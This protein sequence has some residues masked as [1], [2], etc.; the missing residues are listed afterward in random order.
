MSQTQVD[1]KIITKVDSRGTKIRRI[2]CPPGYKLND[3]G[4]SCVPITGS[5]KMQKRIAMRKA[6]RTKRSK[7]PAAQKRANRKRLRAL[8]K[9]KQYGLK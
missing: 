9:R 2:K 3:N 5:E 6:I 1:E 7:G 4:T 8:K